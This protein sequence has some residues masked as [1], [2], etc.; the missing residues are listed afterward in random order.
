MEEPLLL[1]LLDGIGLLADAAGWL[2]VI[3]VA[4]LLAIPLTRR[5]ILALLNLIPAAILFV[6]GI[7]ALFLWRPVGWIV[8]R[9]PILSEAAAR[10]SRAVEHFGARKAGLASGDRAGV[11]RELW[12]ENRFPFLYE[13]LPDDI[14]PPLWEDGKLIGGYDIPWMAD[15]HFGAKLTEGAGRL[16]LAAALIALI[17]QLALWALSRDLT[18]WLPL[19]IASWTLIALGVG[20]APL[21]GKIALI[22]LNM[23][24]DG[25][26]ARLVAILLKTV[27]YR[28]A[29]LRESALKKT[30]ENPQ[31]RPCLVMMDEVQ[32]LATVDPASGLRPAGFATSG[33]TI[34]TRFIR[35][36]GVDER[37]TSFP[38]ATR[39]SPSP[40]ALSNSPNNPSAIHIP[41]Q[42]PLDAALRP[43]EHLSDFGGRRSVFAQTRR[44][45]ASRV[46]KVLID[47]GELLGVDH[48]ML[49]AVNRP[50]P[51]TGGRQHSAGTRRR[52]T[53]L[54][55]RPLDQGRPTAVLLGLD[56]GHEFQRLI[57]KGDRHRLAGPAPPALVRFDHNGDVAHMM[58]LQPN[59]IASP[60]SRQTGQANDVA[61]LRRRGRLDKTCDL[62]VGP[63]LIGAVGGVETLVTDQD[64]H[65]ERA[66]IDAPGQHGRQHLHGVVRL[67]RRRAPLIPPRQKM[68]PHPG[69]AQAGDGEGGDGQGA[70]IGLDHVEVTRPFPERRRRAV[71][72]LRR[73]AIG[74]GEPG[75]GVALARLLPTSD[76]TTIA[77]LESWRARLPFKARPALPGVPVGPSA[78]IG[79][80]RGSF[81]Q[82]LNGADGHGRSPM[83]SEGRPCPRRRP[84]HAG[85]PRRWATVPPWRR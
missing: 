59:K 68:L 9:V 29:P 19:R 67:A 79:H 40:D 74:G 75:Q 49:G 58:P 82:P 43:A 54:R 62:F 60:Q 26:P 69:I 27:L 78:P 83:R 50:G 85:S 31:D 6:L 77:G 21:N 44:E 36:P 38:S 22:T 84:R 32:Q 42:Q 28:E 64:I 17:V 30:G 23:M 25:L 72:E 14:R 76:R 51:S 11:A 71:L 52:Q 13:D 7:A 34:N 1:D 37:D 5:L 8:E 61:D 3:V 55:H 80:A 53:R 45:R 33:A 47:L 10:F 46:V 24:D 73:G 15:R 12:P 41:L 20:D 56:L 63:D 66:A 35:G 48:L 18:P 57:Q 39:F 81:M 65:G 2:A 4:I 70:V 16:G